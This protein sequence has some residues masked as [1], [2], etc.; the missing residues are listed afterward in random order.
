M[1]LNTEGYTTLLQMVKHLH[2]L[3][4]GLLSLYVQQGGIS[5]VLLRCH[6]NCCHLLPYQKLS[7]ENRK[8]VFDSQNRNNPVLHCFGDTGTQEAV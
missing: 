6:L 7:T 2:V 5:E 4:G 1:V 8:P 3:Q